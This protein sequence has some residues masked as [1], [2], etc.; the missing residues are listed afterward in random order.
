[1]IRIRPFPERW[2]L[3][4]LLVGTA[5]G[6]AILALIAGYHLA[7]YL[8]LSVALVGTITIGYWIH[9]LQGEIEDL[10]VLLDRAGNGELGDR[11]YVPRRHYLRELGLTLNHA[12]ARLHR[13]LRRL[14]KGKVDEEAVLA[15]M[16]E[17]VI[18]CDVERKIIRINR[19]A[20]ALLGVEPG[21]VKGRLVGE[22]VRSPD[23]LKLLEL[24]TTSKAPCSDDTAVTIGERTSIFEA[25]GTPLFRQDGRELG[26]LCVLHDVTELRR[27]ERVRR[28]FIANLSHELRTPITSI[29]GFVETLKDGALKEPVEAER[30]LDV[31]ARQADRLHD[32][33]EDLTLLSRIEGTAIALPRATIDVT[34]LAH[35][36]IE[37]LRPFARERQIEVGYIGPE[38]IIINANARLLEH[39]ITNL[40][41]NAIKYSE[42]GQSVEL[43]IQV[44][45][46]ATLISVI[47]HGRGIEPHHCSRIFE[48]F[49]RVDAGRTRADGGSGL[50]LAIVKHIA[51]AHGG[52]VGIESEIG[53]G[54]RFTISLPQ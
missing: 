9:R 27:L 20:G 40:V 53:R 43:E 41:D 25:Y 2:Y 16:V 14:E 42:P 23:V 39:A 19:A 33:F 37:T 21:A 11:L 49:Y 45:A 8:L 26:T 44:D 3:C 1:M 5:F 47:D 29:K 38:K 17:A 18:V 24:V 30:F 54:S 12:M 32:M 48:R 15:H 36:V 7:T 34:A 13:R 50:G 4:L 52:T 46:A 31:I 10:G 22:I 51:Q 35:A 28:D 6:G